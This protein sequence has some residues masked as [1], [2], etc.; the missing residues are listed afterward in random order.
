MHVLLY[1]SLKKLKIELGPAI[2]VPVKRTANTDN[3]F[4]FAIVSIFELVVYKKIRNKHRIPIY[5]SIPYTFL[6]NADGFDKNRN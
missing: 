3:F 5:K 6:L 2:I 4:I 1:V